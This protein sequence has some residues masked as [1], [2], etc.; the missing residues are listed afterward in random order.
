MRYSASTVLREDWAAAVRA[1]LGHYRCFELACPAAR[2]PRSRAGRKT[3]ERLR[4]QHGLTYSVHAP[5]RDLDPAASDAGLLRASRQLYLQAL[6]TGAELQAELV[7]MHP[8]TVSMEEWST[9]TPGRRRAVRQRE[10]ATFR[11][12]AARAAQ[13][14]VRIGLENMP[15]FRAARDVT[16]LEEVWQAVGSPWLGFTVDVGHAHSAGIPPALVLQ[17][18]GRRVWHVHVHDNPGGGDH[19][20]AIGEGTVDWASVAEALVDLDYPGLVV[21]EAMD[22]P[23]QLR[24]G[25]RLRRMVARAQRA[26]GLLR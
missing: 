16:W 9:L 19:H 17:H 7:V 21:D 12:L 6:D 26:R 18:L 4:R 13:L 15:V 2:V 5:F 11:E 3:L 8:A 20:R 24:G 1:G 25:P 10:I 22:L 14:E 23:A